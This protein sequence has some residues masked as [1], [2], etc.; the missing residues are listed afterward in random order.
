MIKGVRQH[1]KSE[2]E[3]GQNDLDLNFLRNIF[4]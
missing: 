1:S 2:L 3:I 4:T